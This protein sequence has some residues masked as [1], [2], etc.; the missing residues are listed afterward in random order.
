MVVAAPSPQ[1]GVEANIIRP[2]K[3]PLDSRV[4]VLL[5]TTIHRLVQPQACA[6]SMKSGRDVRATSRPRTTTRSAKETT[7]SEDKLHTVSKL[8][9]NNIQRLR[10]GTFDV[11]IVGGGINGAVSAAALAA[12]GVRVALVDRGDFAGGTSQSSSNLAWGGIKYME[13]Y[14]FGLVRDLC[15]ARNRLIRHFP[16]TVK[17]IR[18]LTTINA[19]FR[20]HPWLL[21]AGSWLYWL[22]G[23]GFT[24]TP[25]LLNKADVEAEV[26]VVNTDEFAGAIEYSD[27]YLFDNDARF[28][29]NFIQSALQRG[30]NCA[31][32]VSASVLTFSG[33][34]WNVT[35]T[36]VVSGDAFDISASVLINAGG[37]YADELNGTST[38]TTEHRHVFSKGIHLLV[39]RV[40]D[41]TRV[42]AFFA[43]DGRLF[44]VIPMGDKTCIGTTDTR[45][46]TPES[47]VTDA[48]RAFVL[49]NINRLLKLPTPLRADDVI[50]ERCG[51]RPLVVTGGDDANGDFLQMSR[52][53]ALEVDA[54]RRHL[55]VFGGKLTDCINVGEEVSDACASLGINLCNPERRWYGEPHASVRE[56][57]LHQA[58]RHELDKHTRIGA[59]EPLSERLWRRYGHHAFQLLDEI[60]TDPAIGEI[61]IEGT[62]YLHCEIDYIARQEM[63]VRLEDFLR[64]RS[65]ISLVTRHAELE[66]APGLRR[67]CQTLF[68]DAG[69][70]EWRR[71]FESGPD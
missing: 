35:L 6:G 64:R 55:T 9:S 5:R 56:E 37:P 38:Q 18:F 11:L 28:V 1:D 29:F 44:F 58:A 67:A 3:R 14:E 40:T 43:D 17:E 47:A 63:V 49:D 71:Y 61:A 57:F 51:V 39:P 54:R 42:L 21:L 27:A 53:H 62:E 31:N 60:R 25:R 13:S 24:H 23:N 33:N 48:D 66:A 22:I 41:S 15:T 68:G 20:H 4:P 12:K 52:R 16:S 69:D 26:P 59:P 36:D 65:K 34:C 32:Y 30:A 2:G 46:P 10:D 45:V 50:A 8:R 19:T 70:A 7:S